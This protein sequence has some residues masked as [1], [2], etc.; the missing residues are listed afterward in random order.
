[1]FRVAGAQ[2]RVTID[3]EVNE[4]ALLDAVERAAAAA[5]EILLTPEGSLSGYT[6]DF[7]HNE[8]AAAPARVTEARRRQLGLALGTCLVEADGCSYNQVRCYGRDGTF[9]GFHAKALT[10]GTL[11]DPPRGEIERFAVAPVTTRLFGDVTTG[12]LICN[13]LWANPAC[14]P[15]PDPHLTQQSAR[16]GA[17]IIF[18]AVNGGR[19][20]SE[21]SQVAWQYHESNLRMR[22]RAGSLC[23]VTVDSCEPLGMPCSSPSGVINPRG[24]WMVRT[25]P[26]GEELFVSDIDL[27]S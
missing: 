14:T 18:Y 1:M 5:A 22:A 27:E 9:L 25:A 11:T 23:F 26:C 2:M 4:A 8:V 20:G 24:E 13:D 15:G 10:C 12:A 3:V 7:D 16:A 19:D 21:W 17:C 6:A